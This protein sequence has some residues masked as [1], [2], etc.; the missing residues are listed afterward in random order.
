MDLGPEMTAY[1]SILPYAVRVS[2]FPRDENAVSN[3]IV[4]LQLVTDAAALEQLAAQFALSPQVALHIWRRL[5]ALKSD[6][7]EAL[8]QAAGAFYSMGMDEEATACIKSALDLNQQF[9]PALEL[10][11]ALTADPRARRQIYER[12]LEI[13]PGNRTA[14]DNL[15]M[16]GRPK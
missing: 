10:K 14:V 7:P 15:I 11:A 2:Q 6:D 13:E 16:M 3:L 9:I 5:A 12:I 8:V 4:R 1:E